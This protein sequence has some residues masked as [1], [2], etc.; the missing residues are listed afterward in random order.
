MQNDKV[1]ISLFSG[2]GGLDTG[3]EKAGYKIIWANEFDHDAACTWRANRPFDADVMR[4]GDIAD[5]ISELAR[6]SGTVDIIFGGPPCQSFSVA[7]KMDPD[8]ARGKLIFTFLDAVKIVKPKAFIMENVKALG[9]LKKWESVRQK[10]IE[11]AKAL[12]YNVGYFIFHTPDFGVPQNR[13][14]VVFVGVKGGDPQLFLQEMNKLKSHAPTARE[15]LLSV[16]KY[17]SVDNPGTCSAAITLAKSPV[18]RKS[19]YAGM[20]VNGAGR[21]VNLDGLPPTLPATMGGNKTPIVDQRALEHK[22]Q[23][24]WFADYHKKIVAGMCIP[25]TTVIPDFVRRLTLKE[26]AAIQTFPSDYKFCGARNKQYRQIG[27]AVP[28]LFAYK[29]AQAMY[30]V[31]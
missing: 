8:D 9:A 6:Y 16:G 21:P 31:F 17:G 7:G 22:G 18:M 3:F 26:A 30:S 28:S 13:D 1:A 10:Y 2:A 15:V 23:T 25:A 4:E 14:R 24:N 12:G 20:L 19:P 29:V 27:N 5:N 11:Q